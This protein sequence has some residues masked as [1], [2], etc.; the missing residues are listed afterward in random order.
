MMKESLKTQQKCQVEQ[1]QMYIWIFCSICCKH[2]ATNGASDRLLTFLAV[3][4]CVFKCSNIY[5]H[6]H[7][8]SGAH[9]LASLK[10]QQK[11]QVEQGQ[12]N[13]VRCIYIYGYFVRFVANMMLRTVLRADCSRF[14]LL[15]CVCVFKCSNIH[16]HFHGSCR[17][18]CTR[19]IE[20]SA[21]V[22]SRTG[23]D[24]YMYMM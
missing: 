3:S 12:K 13:R 22:S 15:L 5:C 19:F 10:P 21:E 14:W 16:C 17:C 18:T 4:L 23:S 24:V 1:G 7:G 9:A 6:F 8:S 2:D 11:C 20:N